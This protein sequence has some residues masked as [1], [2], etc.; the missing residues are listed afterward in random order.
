MAAHR[1]QHGLA[2]DIPANVKR[3][4]RRRCKFGCVFTD[5][6]EGLVHYHHF[7]PA[8]VDAR[9]HDADGICCL[10]PSHHDRVTRGLLSDREVARAYVEI[11]GRPPEAVEPARGLLD[12]SGTRPRVEIG[13][14][15][16][17][18]AVRSIVRYHGT[19]I[20][21]VEPATANEPACIS[22]ILLD[23]EGQVALE[24]E[25]NA[26]LFSPANWD[27]ESSGQVFRVRT[28]EGRT[29][30]QLR[31]LPQD[32]DGLLPARLRVERLEMRIDS[33]LL[34][35][36][37]DAYLAGRELGDGTAYWVNA[38]VSVG[39]SDPNGAALE[40]MGHDDAARLAE[41]ARR[42][43]GPGVATGD[44][45]IVIGTT[46]GAL[47]PELGIAIAPRCH[48]LALEGLIVSRCSTS[49]AADAVRVGSNPEVR[50]KLARM[51][52]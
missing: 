24:L 33:G 40:F 26:I 36:H 3:E 50:A 21:R 46:S 6:R 2:R 49:Q 28:A 52:P 31:S 11:S 42:S 7:D 41:E 27:V 22:G 37:E 17:A 9:R 51:R 13:G 23:A 35:V 4:I 30:I 39:Q 32:E 1:N 48:D 38:S 45:R 34:L 12:Y 19:D 44:G 18:P 29:P 43:V 15:G 47:V 8:F 20:L 5:C 14:L 16:Y 10:C 25:Q